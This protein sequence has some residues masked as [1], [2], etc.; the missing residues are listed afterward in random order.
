MQGLGDWVTW[1]IQEDWVALVE[2]SAEW[3]VGGS[4]INDEL[5]EVYIKNN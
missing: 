5:K 1:K 3:D 4:T 2:D